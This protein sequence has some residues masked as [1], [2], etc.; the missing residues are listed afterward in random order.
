MYEILSAQILINYWLNFN[1]TSWELSVSRLDVC[2]AG[3]LFLELP[4]F[5]TTL[6]FNIFCPNNEQRDLT[7][8]TKIVL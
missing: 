4:L 7:I 1:K 5:G 2:I 3:M 6:Y 8:S